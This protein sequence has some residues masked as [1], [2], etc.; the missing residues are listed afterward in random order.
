MSRNRDVVGA[1]CEENNA[2]KVVVKEDK[3]WKLGEHT[4]IS[5]QMKKS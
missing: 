4:R 1:G 5:Y 2:G 3:G